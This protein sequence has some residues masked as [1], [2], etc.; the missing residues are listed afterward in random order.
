[1]QNKIAFVILNYKTVDETIILLK[2]LYAQNWYKQI[3]IY[4]VDN[5]SNDGSAETLLQLME[6]DFELIISSENIGF[7]NGNNLGIDKARKD[8]FNFIVCSNSD[9]EIP[10]QEEFLNTII[11]QFNTNPNIAIVAPTVQNLEGSHQNPFKENRFTKK[12][13][14]QL[15]LFYWMGL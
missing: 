1:M 14:I 4:V 5:H 3:K 6:I 7:A 13:I 10:Y 15:K 2:N 8:G 12:E 11:R 9:I